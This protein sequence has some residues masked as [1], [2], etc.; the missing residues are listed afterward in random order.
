[1]PSCL[2]GIW[3]STGFLEKFLMQTPSRVERQRGD[4]VDVT[5]HGV[6]QQCQLGFFGWSQFVIVLPIEQRTPALILLRAPLLFRHARFRP[7]SRRGDDT[8]HRAAR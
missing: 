1:M 5:V 4:S 8:S 6:L 3:S 2:V 7:R